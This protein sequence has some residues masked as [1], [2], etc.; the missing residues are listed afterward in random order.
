M[1]RIKVLQKTKEVQFSYKNKLYTYKYVVTSGSGLAYIYKG[2][3]A[4][5]TPYPKQCTEE[6]R[7]VYNA[8]MDDKEK[9][10]I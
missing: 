2:K 3:E 9:Y 7:E 4:I 10:R 6:G 5:Y 8:F 1:N